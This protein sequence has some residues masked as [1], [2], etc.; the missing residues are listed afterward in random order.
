MAEAGATVLDIKAI[1]GHSTVK[2]TEHY[3]RPGIAAARRVGEAY[4]AALRS[5][6]PKEV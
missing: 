2:V 6:V 1:A 4:S 3:A 5:Y